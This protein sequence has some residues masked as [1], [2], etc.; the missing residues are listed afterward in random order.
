[1]KSLLKIEVEN[2]TVIIENENPVNLLIHADNIINNTI[3]PI[4]LTLTEPISV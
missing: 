3:E 1:M 4:S 2:E